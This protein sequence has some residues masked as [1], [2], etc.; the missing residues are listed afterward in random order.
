MTNKFTSSDELTSL[1]SAW[2]DGSITDEE[3]QRLDDLLRDDPHARRV[4]MQFVDTRQKG[5]ASLRSK[6]EAASDQREA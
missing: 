6:K 5:Q 4:Y 2:A 1:L 3:F